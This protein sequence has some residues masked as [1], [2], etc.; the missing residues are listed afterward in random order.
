MIPIVTSTGCTK[1]ARITRVDAMGVGHQRL[2][3]TQH[4]Q[5]MRL[6]LSVTFQVVLGRAFVSTLTRIHFKYT[7]HAH[8]FLCQFL[9]N[10]SPYWKFPR[11]TGN[12][13]NLLEISSLCWKFPH[14]AGNFL[15]LLEN[16]QQIEDILKMSNLFWGVRPPFFSQ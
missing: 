4:V 1:I 9:L 5:L 3:K 13:L 2:A 15:I 16:F 12:F 6:G 7:L 11:Y 10:S 8:M 14:Y